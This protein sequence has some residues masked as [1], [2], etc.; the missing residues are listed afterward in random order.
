MGAGVQI[1]LLQRE[2][3]SQVSPYNTIQY[4]QYCIKHSSQG[5]YRIGHKGHTVNSNKHPIV[6]SHGSTGEH[7]MSGKLTQVHVEGD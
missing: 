5:W 1:W 2:S 6:G 4:T 7:L 3:S